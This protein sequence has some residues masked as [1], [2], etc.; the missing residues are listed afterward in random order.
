M[1]IHLIML[2]KTRQ[3]ELRALV[4][5][6]ARRI[7]RYAEL[8]ITELRDAAQLAKRRAKATA[9]H[10]LEPAPGTHWVL[11]DADGRRFRS[12][13]F[14]RWLAGLR[15]LGTRELI[16]LCGDAEGFPESLR[17]LAHSRLSLSP[18]TM[19]HELARVVLAEQLYRAFTLL[20]GHPYPK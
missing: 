17:R 4:E 6:Y 1:K 18:L 19:P 5:L 16:F 11:L 9:M 10:R 3:P 14:A 12:C 2:G 8:E 13:E 7:R 15:D 20:A